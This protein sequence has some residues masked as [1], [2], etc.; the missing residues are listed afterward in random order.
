MFC[1]SWKWTN[2]ILNLYN[3][4]SLKTL[5]STCNFSFFPGCFQLFITLF[6]YFELSSSQL[7]KRSD[8]SNSAMKP[9]GVVNI[10]IAFND[11]S[12]I[13]NWKYG[14]FSDAFGFNGFVESLKFSIRL[15]I[16]KRG[17]NV[18]HSGNSYKLL[19]IF[20]NELRS[21]VR[22]DSW[23]V[24][25]EFFSCF[26]NNKLYIRFGHRRAQIEMDNGSTVSIQHTTKIIKKYHTDLR[27][28]D[29]HTN[30]HVVF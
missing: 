4:R 20:W 5:P 1:P 6:K 17:S 9:L 26:L 27:K 18:W 12:R 15:R 28:P 21:I 3:S 25:W 13:L 24:S 16:I 19:E 10:D 30:V 14:L 23:K 22:N 7:I 11:L 2:P 8:P 29:Q